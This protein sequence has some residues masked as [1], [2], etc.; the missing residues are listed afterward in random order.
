MLYKHQLAQLETS[1]LY[2]WLN[3][4]V[5]WEVKLVHKKKKKKQFEGKFLSHKETEEAI[6]QWILL[7][8][9]YVNALPK[10][11]HAVDFGCWLV[12]FAFVFPLP[13]GF[14]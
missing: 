2:N 6:T 3:A 5:D 8:D 7:H 10:T 11:L 14:D 12:A 9:K 1:A 13:V 4:E